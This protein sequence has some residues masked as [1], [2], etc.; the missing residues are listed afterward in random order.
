MGPIGKQVGRANCYL[1]FDASCQLFYVEVCR[2][3]FESIA[4]GVIFECVVIQVRV[5]QRF[6]QCEAN[7]YAVELPNI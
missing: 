6:S 7:L 1:R 5:F 3:E 2:R 4:T